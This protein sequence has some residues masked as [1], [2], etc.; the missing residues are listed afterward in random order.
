MLPATSFD[1]VFLLSITSLSENKSV[2]C[3][4][5]FTNP[6]PR[7]ILKHS[8]D[9]IRR[10]RPRLGWRGCLC[11]DRQPSVAHWHNIIHNEHSS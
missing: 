4:A 1:C 7:A 2:H 8:E 3:T 6:L 5:S 10:L 11:A 9:A